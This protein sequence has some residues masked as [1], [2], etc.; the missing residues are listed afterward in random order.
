MFEDA[1]PYNRGEITYEALKNQL[2]KHGGLL[3]NLSITWV[4]R[5]T[6]SIHPFIHP[7]MSV[8]FENLYLIN[9]LFGFPL[10]LSCRIDRWLVP[11]GQDA[12]AAKT[13]SKLCNSIPI[14]HQLTPAYMRN[15]HVFVTYLFIYIA[16][17]VCLFVS[18]AIQYRA[19]NGFVIV[20]RACGKLY[21]ARIIFDSKTKFE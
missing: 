15:N 12:P 16:I 10:S 6:P 5:W 13:K 14:P 3:E 2:H 1:D 4:D 17:N 9:I 21:Q 7:A 19:S 11:T 18:R 20:A 8:D